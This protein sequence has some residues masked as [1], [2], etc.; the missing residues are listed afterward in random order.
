M[1]EKILHK[2][3]NRLKKDAFS[4]FKTAAKHFDPKKIDFNKTSIKEII[5]DKHCKLIFWGVGTEY[6]LKST[7]LLNGFYIQE[8]RLIDGPLPADYNNDRVKIIKFNDDKTIGM[9]KLI[10]YLP[11]VLKGLNKDEMT[12]LKEGLIILNRWRNQSVHLGGS[13]R[14]NS[15]EVQKAGSAINQLAN[16]KNQPKFI[17]ANVTIYLDFRETNYLIRILEV[18]MEDEEGEEFA[19]NSFDEGLYFGLY[20]E[21]IE[22]N[23]KNASTQEIIDYIKKQMIK[24]GYI[25]VKDFDFEVDTD[26][27]QSV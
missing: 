13:F 4:F 23:G 27:I 2:Q 12:K 18:K 11:L 8:T 1:N 10:E 17:L 25:F 5:H 20:D 21:I 14:E 3:G 9:S 26:N 16:Y 19:F 24:E 6:L 22:N 7:F 15:A